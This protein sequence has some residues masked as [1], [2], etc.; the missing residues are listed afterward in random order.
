MMIVARSCPHRDTNLQSVTLCDTLFHRAWR[1]PSVHDT[2]TPRT[3]QQ[4]PASETVSREALFKPFPMVTHLRERKQYCGTNEKE[5]Q[6]KTDLE[7]K[8]FSLS[9]DPSTEKLSS[10]VPGEN[11]ELWSSGVIDSFVDS[12]TYSLL[13]F[14]KSL[15]L[16][17]ES[18]LTPPPLHPLSFALACS[19]LSPTSPSPNSSK[20]CMLEY[21]MSSETTSESQLA[22]QLAMR[23]RII[24]RR[25]AKMNVY[26]REEC[27][28]QNVSAVTKSVLEKS[29]AVCLDTHIARTADLATT[30]SGGK[31]EDAFAADRQVWDR[32]RAEN[33][34]SQSRPSTSINFESI[35]KPQPS[36]SSKS[37]ARCSIPPAD[38]SSS[39]TADI[40]TPTQSQCTPFILQLTK[41]SR[42][43]T[44]KPKLLPS[45]KPGWKKESDCSLRKGVLVSNAFRI[46]S[47]AARESTIL[48]KESLNGRLVSSSV[49]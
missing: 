2:A 23:A 5:C 20:R 42:P 10:T 15:K 32:F 26:F 16:V 48:E 17:G 30:P 7:L 22:T 38:I 21:E 24:A 18:V 4:S 25:K 40:T 29:F 33:L 1:A 39:C 37:M 13:L 34:P 46:T 3:V 27:E 44:P 28:D 43:S 41:P 8:P 14:T 47:T 31:L 12:D 49:A 11:K 36:T 9:E 35:L 19:S 45:R 6:I